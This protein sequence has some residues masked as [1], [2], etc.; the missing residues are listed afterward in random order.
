MVHDLRTRGRPHSAYV[1]S[2]II[3]VTVQIVR[4]P[5]STTPAWD[6]VTSW[7]LALGA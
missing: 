6:A 7:L 1:V 3:L 2:G 4:I 5:L